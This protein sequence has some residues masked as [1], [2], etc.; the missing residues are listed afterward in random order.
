MSHRHYQSQAYEI[1]Y[2]KITKNT[3]KIERRHSMRQF[4]KQVQV[5]ETEKRFYAE[6]PSCGK[7]M[8]SRRLPMLCRRKDML[9]HFSAGT[10]GGV[11]QTLYNR[12]QVASVQNLARF[13]NRCNLCGKW[14]CDDCY[15]V[16]HDDGA[17]I[18]CSENKS[19]SI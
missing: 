3:T 11:R 13:F 16:L 10:A 15:D 7:R 17:C 4:Y 8:Y 19:K 9:K 6:C 14:I 1:I 12:R 5:D 18:S 2:H